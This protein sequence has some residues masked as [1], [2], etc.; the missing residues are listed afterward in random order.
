[1]KDILVEGEIF[2]NSR[3]Q[4]GIFNISKNRFVDSDEKVS[5]RGT[6]IPAPI[7]FHTHIGDSFIKEEPRG[8]IPEVVGPA[9]F[10]MR[11]LELANGKIVRAG[12]RASVE[13]MK[14]VGTS[15]FVDFRESG[16]RGIKAL[17]KLTGI[18]G[19]FLS[20]PSND[21][22]VKLLLEKS[23]GF[24][25]SSISD[26]P[27]KWLESLSIK[28]HSAGKLFGIHFSENSREQCN[29]LIGL[30]PD[31]IVHATDASQED[32]RMIAS[33]GIPVVVTPRSNIFYGKRQ[34]YSRLVKSGLSVMIGTDNVFVTEPNIWE[35]AS[36]LYRLQRSNGYI[37]PDSILSMI[38]ENPR[39]FMRKRGLMGGRD[40]YVLFEGKE[41]SSYQIISKP[42]YYERRI[43]LNG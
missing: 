4:H 5:Y 39:E 10:K 7:N 1:M 19:F 36:F 16:L 8:G 21:E 9:G 42:N 37:S 2:H 18:D 30:R 11:Q 13:Y 41:L 6:L 31:F 38:T 24:G 12:M 28:A 34:D 15:A 23:D 17:P 20:R 27:L 35:E 25:M 29:S 33:E 22:D 40:R 43:L 3:F 26:Y 14:R 32:L